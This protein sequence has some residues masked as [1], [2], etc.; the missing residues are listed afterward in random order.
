MDETIIKVLL[1]PSNLINYVRFLIL[2]LLLVNIRNR[3][4]LCTA[5]ILASGLI[6]LVDGPLARSSGK[7]SKFGQ[8]LDVSMDRTTAIILM[9]CLA[10][11]Y[12]KYW[13]IFCILSITE[14]LKDFGNL[15]W[16]QHKLIKSLE[17]L[18]FT[19]TSTQIVPQNNLNS[20]ASSHKTDSSFKDFYWHLFEQYVWYSSDLFF[21][22][23]YYAYFVNNNRQSTKQA[24]KTI[25]NSDNTYINI[26]TLNNQS[27]KKPSNYSIVCKFLK[28]LVEFINY[29]MKIFVNIYELLSRKA[30][31]NLYGL[32]LI[33]QIVGFLF[34]IGAFLKFYLNARN[35]VFLLSEILSYDAKTT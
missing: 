22:T 15:Y 26:E 29:F 8:F 30:K 25:L 9:F 28:C 18:T 34:F 24:S 4:L 20:F 13:L 27:T 2:V 33:I 11:F 3:P 6:D 5:L 31:F 16:S 19:K 10:L 21:I 35:L 32:R 17:T 14:V 23:I 12:Q 7:T 1:Y